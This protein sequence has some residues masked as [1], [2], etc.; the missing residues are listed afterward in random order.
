MPTTPP[1]APS[2]T[3]I[4][5]LKVQ[6]SCLHNDLEDSHWNPTDWINTDEWD[7]SML[8]LKLRYF[9]WIGSDESGTG[10]RWCVYSPWY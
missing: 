5:S 8:A 7:G 3:T 6:N 1:H 9:L 4:T 10:K 2:F